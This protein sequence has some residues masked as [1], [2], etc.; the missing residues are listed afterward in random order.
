MPS[1]SPKALLDAVNASPAAVATHDKAAWLQL[2]DS[3]FHLEDP[4]GSRPVRDQVRLAQFYESFIAP[5]TIL[6]HTGRDYIG[7]DSP[8]CYSVWRDLSLE[9]ALSSDVRVTVP[10]HLHYQLLQQQD[11]SLR[12]RRLAAHWALWPMIKQLAPYGIKAIPTACKLTAN[13]WRNLG[14][15]GLSGFGLALL[16]PA[17]A[18]EK[19]LE[20]VLGGQQTIAL[21]N[22]QGQAIAQQE[23]QAYRSSKI[24]CAG[25]FI[26]ATL[27]N[28]DNEG[29]LVLARAHRFGE[30]TQAQ[31][32]CD[33]D[34]V[35][36]ETCA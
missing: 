24:I 33:S 17:S 19:L 7:Q 5:N 36:E 15:F 32:F 27:C 6:F 29:L 11:G 34:C 10:M 31:F 28:G 2:F 23:L 26:T 22:S 1:P 12:V 8:H 4:V 13:I 14:W 20:E 25:R 3:T 16:T 35:S 18:H 9:I 30:I 21:Q